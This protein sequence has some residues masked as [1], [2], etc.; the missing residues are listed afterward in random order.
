MRN[1]IVDQQNHLQ[2]AQQLFNSANW[3]IEKLWALP[4]EDSKECFWWRYSLLLSRSCRELVFCI[5]WKYKS[6]IHHSNLRKV[7]M[8]EWLRSQRKAKKYNPRTLRTA[9]SKSPACRTPDK[10]L[11]SLENLFDWFSS[12][13]GSD[14]P[15]AGW[16]VGDHSPKNSIMGFNGINFLLYWFKV[17]SPVISLSTDPI[18]GAYFSFTTG[19][20]LSMRFDTFFV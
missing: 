16:K 17:D 3:N 12:A 1:L 10:I 5:I 15:K 9:L 2:H 8:L 19:S 4:Y 13:D 7:F 6:A 18:A 11:W 20:C 14:S